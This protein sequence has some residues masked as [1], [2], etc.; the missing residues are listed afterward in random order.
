[1]NRVRL[2]SALLGFLLAVAGIAVDNRL[3]VWA[4]MV[5]LAVALALRLR[6]RKRG[7]PSPTDPR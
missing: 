2:F 7:F 4:A 1:M 5:V 3:L 6:A